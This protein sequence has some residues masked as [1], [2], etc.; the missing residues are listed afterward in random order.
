MTDLYTDGGLLLRNPSPLG[1]TAAFV[2]VREGVA[3]E[4]MAWRMD[5]SQLGVVEVSS[6]TA[7]L[8]AAI[9]ALRWVGVEEPGWAGTLHTD[10]EVTAT[11][12]RRA[13]VGLKWNMGSVPWRMSTWFR[14]AM[15]K[16]GKFEVI[17]L[18]GHP[19]RADL[20]AGVNK[21]GLPVSRWNVLADK[22][23]NRVK[24]VERPL[25]TLIGV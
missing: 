7:E 20:A 18:G 13:Q 4:Q 19:T 21:Y 24:E 11:R 1:C 22:L 16:V 3:V 15:R 17:E 25:E 8:L 14:D 6:N 10:S 9:F 23:C 12:L 5:C 2:A